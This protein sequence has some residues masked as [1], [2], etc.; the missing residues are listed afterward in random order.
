M[1]TS[2]LLRLMMKTRNQMSLWTKKGILDIL[3][4]LIGI[5][6]LSA[7]RC[8]RIHS[9]VNLGLRNMLLMS[10][11]DQSGWWLWTLRPNCRSSWFDID[12]EV[13]WLDLEDASC[14]LWESSAVRN[15]KRD[16]MVQWAH[17]LQARFGQIS[18]S[19]LLV[20]IWIEGLSYPIPSFHPQNSW[21]WMKFPSCPKYPKVKSVLYQFLPVVCQLYRNKLSH[22]YP[23]WCP[24]PH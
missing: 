13:T 1:K 8:H 6:S 3:Q 10:W 12:V 24:D 23:N 11:R 4:L 2:N 16:P 9:S 19:D 5:L 7:W 14:L 20:G 15:S 17:R 22:Y 18:F 21:F